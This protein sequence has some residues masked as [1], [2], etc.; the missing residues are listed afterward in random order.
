MKLL[1]LSLLTLAS[2]VPAHAALLTSNG[3]LSSSDPTYNRVNESLTLSGTG[4]NVYYDVFYFHTTSTGSVRIETMTTAG[5]YDSFITL[6][7]GSFN[8]ASPTTNDVEADDDDG[9]GAL[10]KIVR[11]LNGGNNY[12]VVVTSYLNGITGN[13]S[14]QVEGNVAAGLMTTGVPEP[15]TALL[16][17]PA[18]AAIYFRRRK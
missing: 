13:Y 18:L 2:L 1:S 16:A 14:L 9:A 5:Q 10:S 15:S 7:Q 17:V 6:Y 12:A 11:S 3:S 4:T 8:A